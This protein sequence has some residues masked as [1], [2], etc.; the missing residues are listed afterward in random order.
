VRTLRSSP[1]ASSVMA[2]RTAFD[3]SPPWRAD[4]SPSARA[5]LALRLKV[6]TTR[7]RLDRQIATGQ[8]WDAAAELALRARQLSDPRTQQKIARNLRRVISY[9]DRRG[10]RRAISAVVIDPPAVAR[11]RRAIVEL[12]EQL[13]RAAAVNPRGIVLAQALLT[14]GRSPLFNP[15]S[16]QS[17]TDAAREVHE[18]LA[19]RP[20]IG[21]PSLAA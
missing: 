15:Y 17:V 21:F 12:A 9:V 13:E 5:R 3:V 16:E 6:Y 8:P 18:A 7:G 20:T 19:E 2:T 1:P 14:D 11:G 4:R 10:S